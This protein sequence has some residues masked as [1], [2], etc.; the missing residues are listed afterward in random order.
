MSYPVFD[1]RKARENMVTKSKLN[2]RREVS[3]IVDIWKAQVSMKVLLQARRRQGSQ[4]RK[5]LFLD[6]FAGSIIDG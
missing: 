3:V 5:C 4:R 2:S 1:N 6:R